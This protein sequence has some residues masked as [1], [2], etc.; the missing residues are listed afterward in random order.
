MLTQ[1]GLLALLAGSL[2]LYPA[3]MTKQ[4]PIPRASSIESPK[5]QERVCYCPTG[6]VLIDPI[7]CTCRPFPP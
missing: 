2:F 6:T 7:T 5:P 3:G 1:L 4:K